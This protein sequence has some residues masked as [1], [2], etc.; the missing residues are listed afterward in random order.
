MPF[1]F[2]PDLTRFTFGS[3]CPPSG[4]CYRAHPPGQPLPNFQPLV[5]PQP[6]LPFACAIG[7][8]DRSTCH[9]QV[10]QT[11]LWHPVFKGGEGDQGRQARAPLP[12]PVMPFC[13]L[14][15]L[16]RVKFGSARPPLGGCYRAR[17]PGQ[18]LPNFQPRGSPQPP[19]P[20]AY[21]LGQSDRSTCHWQIAQTVL[22]H[23]VFGGGEGDPRRADLTL[24]PASS[25]SGAV[26]CRI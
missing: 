22:W 18:A 1:C 14:P 3:A 21:A 11:V 9:W 7:Q 8:S 20:C 24:L 17:P 15:D 19:L 13:F 10:A 25:C 16:P 5:S 26:S 2:L 23:P 12:T 4:G 6:S